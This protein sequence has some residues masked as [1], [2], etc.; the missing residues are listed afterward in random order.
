MKLK[1]LAY[2]I[3]GKVSGSQEIEI[4]GAAGITDAKHGDITFLAG[5][6]H[7]GDILNTKASAVIAKEEI[8]GLSASILV[9]D[10]PYFTFARA[11]EVFHVKPFKPIGISDKA[12]V[13]TGASIGKDVSIYPNVY[14]SSNA[15]IGLRVILYPGVFIGEGTSISDDSIIYPNATIRENVKIGRKVIVHAGAVIGADGFGYIFEKGTH[16]KIPQVGGVI[17][18]DNVEIGANVTIDRA[19]TGNT[20]I[21][22]GTKIDNLVQIGH[23]VNIGKNCLML[24]QAGISGS[25]EMGN[26]VILAGQVGVRDHVKIGN[27]VMVGSQSG[28]AG[29]IA[30]NQIYSGSPAI[31]HKTWLRAQ[32]IY[33]KL[34]EYIKRLHEIERKIDK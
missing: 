7:L 1:E 2:L 29:D 4:T 9:S 25:V 3:G 28:I 18:G 17:I 32:S 21:G 30:D 23:N 13:C 6:K 33:S 16:Y 34:P 14:I 5:K 22:S 19:T 27:G 15:V 11:L 12:T 24:G 20:V 31:P 8:E 26:G 10:N